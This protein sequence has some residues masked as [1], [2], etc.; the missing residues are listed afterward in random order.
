MGDNTQLNQNTTPGDII[1]T[2]A[3]G[4]VKHE[5][6]IVEY[7]DGAGGVTIVSAANP[8]PVAATIST[9]GLA[10]SGKQDT[11]NTSLGSIDTKTPALG[12][13]VSG[14]SVPVVLP[15]AQI[16][17]LTPPA[18]ITNYANETGGHLASL[19]TKLPAQGQALSAASLPVVLPAAQISTLTPPAAI[20]NYA[21]ETGGNLAAILAKII[22][23]PATAANQVTEIAS[24]ANLDVALSTRL[25]PA[26]TLTAVT[27]VGTITNT[28]PT[29]EVAPTAILNGKTTVAT[30]GSRV[31]LASTTPCKSVTIKALISNTGLIYVGNS[32][33]AASNGFQL[34][35]GDSIS[36]D[37][38]N[39]T[40][41]EIDSQNNGEG[42]TYL[43]V[44]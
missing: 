27:T 4:G 24:L 43:G 11:G 10:T 18:A 39:L 35:A 12:Q 28:V 34:S 30:A 8:L 26:D 9:A 25:K 37:I 38:S 40:T 7:S 14:S 21:N 1:A 23:A 16:T 15:A 44:N 13:A 5:Q 31:V 29:Q 2:L 42:V 17:T 32:T 20:T 19:D 33:V 6:V 36:L 41:V 22:A 3:I